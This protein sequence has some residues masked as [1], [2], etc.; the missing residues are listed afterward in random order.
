MAKRRRAGGYFDRLVEQTGRPRP[1]GAHAPRQL[2]WGPPRLLMEP[3]DAPFGAA[4]PQHAVR[5]TSRP[6]PVPRVQPGERTLPA[7]AEPEPL[8]DTAPP[9][10]LASPV[11][12]ATRRLPPPVD[13]DEPN[14]A[15]APRTAAGRATPA[16]APATRPAPAR[17]ATPTRPTAPPVQPAA[18]IATRPLP[19]AVGHALERLAARSLPLPT[20]DATV[21][22]RLPVHPAGP[23]PTPAALAPPARPASVPAPSPQRR[24]AGRE[25]QV[26]IGT[27]E[28]TIAGPPQPLASPLPPPVRHVVVAAPAPATRLS[29]PSSGYGLGQG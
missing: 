7:M 20:P 11:R 27:I 14:S 21:T 12:A 6:R 1:A 4:E 23:P 28:V 17:P 8:V 5:G 3:D 25:P 26:R 16:T 2:A 19:P 22:P 13:R 15:P 24:E 18:A 9:P 10:R 29:R